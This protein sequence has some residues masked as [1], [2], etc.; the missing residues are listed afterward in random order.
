MIN[1]QN[2]CYYVGDNIAQWHFRVGQRVSHVL[3][4]KLSVTTS[5]LP[6]TAEKQCNIMGRDIYRD[7]R[8]SQLQLATEQFNHDL[9]NTNTKYQLI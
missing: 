7:A 6:F 5:V 3:L 9:I 2:I 1:M 4:P 8:N